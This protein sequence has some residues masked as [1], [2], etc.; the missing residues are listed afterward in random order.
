MITCIYGLEWIQDKIWGQILFL[1]TVLKFSVT[2][3]WSDLL[4]LAMSLTVF[5]LKIKSI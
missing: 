4:G 1:R 3:E 5:A 2:S